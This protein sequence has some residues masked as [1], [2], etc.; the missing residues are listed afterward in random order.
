MTMGEK[1]YRWFKVVLGAAFLVVLFLFALNG[2]YS[3]YR[4][5]PNIAFDKWGGTLVELDFEELQGEPLTYS[6]P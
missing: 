3:H 5:I 4:S 6:H 2:R 1:A